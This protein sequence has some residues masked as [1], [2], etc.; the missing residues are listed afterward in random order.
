M[1][2]Y[3]VNVKETSLGFVEI[4]AASEEEARERA[5]EA[6]HE[7]MAHWHGLEYEAQ[8]VTKINAA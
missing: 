3:T 5:I 2:K 1:N 8:S 6:C 4:E 7:G